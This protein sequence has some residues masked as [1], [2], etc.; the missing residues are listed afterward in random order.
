MDSAVLNG[1]FG[2]LGG[3]VKSA[4][5]LT[6]S[7]L[8]QPEITINLKMTAIT[9]IEGIVAGIAIGY[10]IPSPIAALLGGAGISELA[11]LNDLIY[12]KNKRT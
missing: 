8:E 3:L 1:L 2:G 10:V 12:P 7:K 5:G 4:F 11:D 6:K 9:V